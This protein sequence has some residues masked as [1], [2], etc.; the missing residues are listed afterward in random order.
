M[1][2]VW[3]SVTLHLQPLPRNHLQFQFQFQRSHFLHSLSPIFIFFFCFL[4]EDEP[5]QCF[6]FCGHK[7]RFGL[8]HSLALLRS[9]EPAVQRLRLLR[10]PSLSPPSNSCSLSFVA[11]APFPSFRCL[12]FP[13]VQRD[14]SWDPGRS[15]PRCS[16]YHQTL[17][18]R[19]H[20][21]FFH[22]SLSF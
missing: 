19:V 18:I 22:S 17:Q 7:H 1:Q 8:R 15:W 4:F 12:G 14:R 9:Q 3:H 10:S 16:C 2:T 5:S 20:F 11:S 6:G 13:R 21:L